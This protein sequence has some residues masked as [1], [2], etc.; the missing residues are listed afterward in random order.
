MALEH[1]AII[2][3]GNGR[4]ARLRGE[5][6]AVGHRAGVEALRK[7]VRAAKDFGVRYLSVYAFSTENWK[8]PPEEV[9]VLMTLLVEYLRSE[10]DELDRSGVRI[11]FIGDIQGL[12][13]VC[14]A[15]MES[16]RQ[17]T[18]H[19]ADLILSIAVNYGGR[20][21]IVRAVRRAV[22]EG[23]RPEEITEQTFSGLLDTDGMP[24]PDLVIRPGGESRL[25]NFLIYQTHY[26][27]I[28]TTPVLWPDFDRGE[29]ERALQDY[30][31]RERR[32]GGVGR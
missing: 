14:Q 12:P 22:A 2:M 18:A 20:D 5:P 17:R 4:W 16:A 1:V 13:A 9:E 25:S 28:Y 21:E 30:A 15:E 10:V 24:D 11:Q 19:N 3:D 7:V 8:R 23:L 6:R 32:Y 27:E 29:L 31:Q 26:S